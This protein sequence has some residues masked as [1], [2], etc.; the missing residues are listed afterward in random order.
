MQVSPHTPTAVVLTLA[1]LLHCAAPPPSADP[2]RTGAQTAERSDTTSAGSVAPPSTPKPD[3]PR[4][5]GGERDACSEA[6]LGILRTMEA[7]RAERPCTADADCV[8]V[9]SPASFDRGARQVVARVDAAALEEVA[10]RHLEVCGAF[11]RDA[12]SEVF[13][14]VEARCVDARCA[15]S[16]TTFH[17]SE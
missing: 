14:V 3:E 6:R 8:A 15:A 16:E 7:S 17:P 1:A 13:T 10:K 4:A 2:T 12:P 9:T 11:H 5:P